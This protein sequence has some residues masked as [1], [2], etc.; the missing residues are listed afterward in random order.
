MTN[1]TEQTECK[2]H[3][4]EEAKTPGLKCKCI[5]NCE[6]CSPTND[7]KPQGWKEIL[8]EKLEMLGQ[9]YW[10][11]V[12]HG[13]SKHD[14]EKRFI[15]AFVEQ[16]I[17]LALKKKEDEIREWAESDELTNR[18]FN[19]DGMVCLSGLLEKLSNK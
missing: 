8:G 7:P 13:G 11:D 2:C 14:K 16:E 17:S 10:Q 9:S 12:E 19:E 15:I 1:K 18:G 5:K 3:C 6:H 4:H